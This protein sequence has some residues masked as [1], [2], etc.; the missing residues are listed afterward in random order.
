MPFS[1]LLLGPELE[2]AFQALGYT[3]PFPV[4]A[5]TIPRVL[6]GQDLVVE[7]PTGSGKTVAFLAP[8]P[9]SYTHLTLPT[10][11]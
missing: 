6:T 11:A 5:Q 10:K 3:Q 2:R 1:P 8:L 7:A 4:Q 9:V